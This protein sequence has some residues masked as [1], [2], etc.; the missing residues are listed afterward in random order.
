MRVLAAAFAYNER[1]YIPY[2][3]EY[4]RSQGCDLLILDNYSTDGT[5]EWLVEN[6]VITGRVDSQEAFH[7]GKL[8][9]ALLKALAREKPDWVLYTGIDTYFYFTGTISEEVK[10]AV[11]HKCNMIATNHIECHNIG[12]EFHLPFQETY[13]YVLTNNRRRQMISKYNPDYFKFAADNILITKP[14]VYESD[15]FLINYGMCKSKKERDLTLARRQ[16]AWKLGEPLG[17][18]AGYVMHQQRNWTWTKEEFTDIRTTKY[19]KMMTK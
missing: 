4:Y 7:L 11:D 12:E 6:K 17:H 5:Y 2:M 14:E 18:G 3:V 10:K 19:Y 9:G 1:P 13:F 16:K 15:G 8:Q